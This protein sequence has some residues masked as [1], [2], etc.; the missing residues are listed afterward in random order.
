MKKLI[1]TILIGAVL[2][3]SAVLGGRALYRH[4]VTNS[5]SDWGGME[6]PDYTQE[7][8]QQDNQHTTDI[9]E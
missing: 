9:T 3:G 8:Q 1:V 2:L 4:F 7:M 5:I 6:N